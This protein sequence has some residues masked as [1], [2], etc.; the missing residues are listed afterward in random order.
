[1]RPRKAISQLQGKSA[2]YC[3]KTFFFFGGHLKTDEK[4]AQK[5]CARSRALIIHI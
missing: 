1:M 5:A 3:M 4:H 2:R